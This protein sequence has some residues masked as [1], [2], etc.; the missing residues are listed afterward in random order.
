MQQKQQM[1]LNVDIKNTTSI[2][3]PDGGVIFQQG[4]L[5][6]NVS[7]FVVGADED[8]LMP[9]PVFFDPTTGKILESTIP[10]ELRDQYKD[11]VIK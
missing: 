3:T 10:V 2:E 9:I 5:L 11:H 8:A 4:V 6:R 7:K 1:N